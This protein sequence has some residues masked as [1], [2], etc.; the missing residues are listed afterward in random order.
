MSI[1]LHTGL[2]LYQKI[3][4]QEI[5]VIVRMV[6]DAGLALL[7]HNDSRVQ[8]KSIHAFPLLDR[9][10]TPDII[11]HGTHEVLAR[12]LH[13]AYLMG[14][15][16]E[17]EETEGDIA[18]ESW[19]DL[20]EETKEANRKQ[21][22]RISHILG[23]H[24]FRIAPLTDWTAA[25]RTFNEEEGSDEVESMA[26]MEHDL[27]CQEMRADGYE[28]GEVRSKEKKTHPDLVPWKKLKD[29]EVDKNKK[30]TRDLPRV[31]ARA[32]FQI[33]REDSAQINLPKRKQD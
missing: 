17:M 14:L 12:D 31:L 25:E 9:T 4:N 23:E 15:K 30:F 24:G 7:L 13:E 10:C 22:G 16:S 3:R 11:L 21:A 26:S 19:D 33:E 27:W 32:G 8:T 29:D 5:P 18:L 2:T 20:S 6:E 28:L 1:R